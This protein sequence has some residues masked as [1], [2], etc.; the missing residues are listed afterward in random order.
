MSLTSNAFGNTNTGIVGKINNSL[1][2]G[3]SQS[4]T[5]LGI[6]AK[7]PVIAPQKNTLP[8]NQV[9]TTPGP[10]IQSSTQNGTTG[11]KFDSN[12]LSLQRNLNSKGAG[13]KEDG[14]LGPL[15]SAAIAKYSNQPNPQNT[16]QNIPQV[17][18]PIQP[19]GY[20]PNAGLFG[21][22]IT[23]LANQSQSQPINNIS[24]Q[25]ESGDYQQR[26][27]DAINAQNRAVGI[28]QALNQAVNDQTKSA[29]PITFQQ[30]RQGAIQRDYGVQADAAVRAAQNAQNIASTTQAGLTS[31]GGLRNTQQG[32]IQQ[33]LQQAAGFSAPQLAGFN[34]QVFNPVTGTM[35]QGGGT[36]Q[37]AVNSVAQKLS[38]G[39]MTYSDALQALSGYGQG[40]VNALQQALPSEFN[41]AQSNTLAGQQGSVG[42]NYK[43]ADNALTNVENLIAGLSSAQRTNIP[44][45]NKTANWI[46]TQFGLGSDQTRAVTGAVQSLRNAYASLLASA[47]GG[48]PTDYSG[49]AQAEIP[50]E[51]TPN[52]L[53]AIRHNFETLGKARAKILGNPGTSG[54]STSGSGLFNW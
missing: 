46:S 14:I 38:N 6:Q 24:Q 50:N 36:M 17:N 23:G 54:S 3:S 32:L 13:L 34:Q 25:L 2:L 19:T 31:A 49:Q 29:I 11:S 52:D 8:P 1:G 47:K 18:Q 10:T 5:Q 7:A 43:L 9:K 51:P 20:T 22:L 33:A 30:G 42:V 45:I 28:N 12:V 35:G 27:Q 15:T 48:T 21:E 41:I 16:P 26:I 44:V 53:K 37:D 40:G 4:N 39:Q